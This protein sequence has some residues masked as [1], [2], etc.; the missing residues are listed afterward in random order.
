MSENPVESEHPETPGAVTPP[1]TE[2]AAPEPPE[3]AEAPVNP[4]APV[5]PAAAGTAEDGA[6]LAADAVPVPAD[7]VADDA[8][9]A[10]A[11]AR[12]RLRRGR[13]AAVAGSVL[14]LAA[15]VAGAGYTVVTVQDAD[16]DAGRPVFEL[17]AA[18][19]EKEP[20]AKGLRA[21][22]LPWEAD[23]YAQGPD[24]GEYGSDAEFNG[25]EATALRK[26]SVSSLPTSMR[27]AMERLIDKEK[28]K[29]MAMRSY[30]SD[31][32][33][34]DLA[35]KGFTASV[36]L[37]QMATHNDAKSN[38]ANQNAAFAALG[39]LKEGPKIKGHPD[40]RCFRT[41]KEDDVEQIDMFCSAYSGDVLVTITAAGM[42]HFDSGLVGKFVTA[43]LD[44]IGD[45]GESV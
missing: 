25:R 3:A 10:P 26:E 31:D 20:E 32:A 6:P 15:V 1:T 44:H 13:A 33:T 14:L 18:H 24:L 34:T 23:T 16:V 12:K 2:G 41:P 42:E 40:A 19:K 28:I 9:P 30:I 21:L 5:S 11:P 38:S 43:Q 45:P 39:V 7:A 36:V 29:G 17:P 4:E 8:S 37:T 35:H 27:R 22:M